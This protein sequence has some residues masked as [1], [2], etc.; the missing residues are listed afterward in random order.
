MSLRYEY[1]CDLCDQPKGS[2]EIYGMTW[3]DGPR[4]V[5]PD[6]A[7]TDQRHICKYCVD[8]ILKS[9]TLLLSESTGD[10]E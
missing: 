7:A 5:R 8:G 9:D 4:L 1:I 2:T 3:S 6:R 10:D